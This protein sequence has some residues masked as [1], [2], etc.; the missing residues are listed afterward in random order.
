MLKPQSVE[1]R[2]CKNAPFPTNSR[3]PLFVNFKIYLVY[4][5]SL[6]LSVHTDFLYSF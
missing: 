4:L 6:F 3:V 5:V 1:K 2:K